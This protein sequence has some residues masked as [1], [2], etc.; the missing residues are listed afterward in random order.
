MRTKKNKLTYLEN[1]Y[2]RM[3]AVDALYFEIKYI[4]KAL[5]YEFN[6]ELLRQGLQYFQECYRSR[7]IKYP[8]DNIYLEI[9]VCGIKKGLSQEEACEYSKAIIDREMKFID[10]SILSGFYYRENWFD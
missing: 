1:A 8:G 2:I 4:L 9:F 7:P 3:Q 6:K 5:K 10:G